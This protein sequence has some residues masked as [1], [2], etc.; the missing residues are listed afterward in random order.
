MGDPDRR[1]TRSPIHVNLTGNEERVAM[2][3]FELLK[4][5]GTGAYGKVFLVR[6]VTGP[7]TNHLYAMKVLQKC[8]LVKKEKTVE[9]TKTE[10]NVLEHVRESP[11]LVTLH[12]AFQ[13]EAKL[14]LILDY[15]SGGEL[16]TH[17]YQRDNFSEDAVRF[18]SGEVIL[19]LEHLHKLGVVYR[20]I[21]L[22]NILLDSEGHVVL[23]DFGLSKE[24]LSEEEERTYSFCGTT[25]YMAP[26]IIRGQGG[27]GKIVDWWSLGI[28]I[29][30]LLTGASPFTLEGE[31][32]TQSEVS[33]RILKMDPSLPSFLSFEARD[34]LHK[35]L[36]K[37]PK[38]RL[39]AAGA[40]QIKEHPFYKQDMDWEALSLRKVNPPF[41]PS[42]RNET[43][44]SNFAEEFTNLDPVYSPAGTPPSGA[45]VF[46]GYSFIAPSVL[47]GRNAVMRD[48]AA[49]SADKPGSPTLALSAA[50]KDSPFFQCYEIDL[51]EP[52][53]GSGS[54]SICRKCL[55]R[56]T[57]KEYAVKIISRRME[58]NTQREVAALRLCQGHTNIVALHEVLH[59]Q[60]HSYLV[61]ELLD[62][63]ELLDRIKKQARFSEV[64][65][66]SLM[67]SL[68]SAVAHM[69]SA[70]VVHRDL[71]PEN[72]LLSSPGENA[73]LKVI[74]FG[75]ARLRPPGSRPLHTPCF[76]LH[77]AAPELFSNQ[78]YDELCDLWTLGVILYTMLSGQVPFQVKRGKFHNRAADIIQKIKEGDFSMEG[79]CWEH[80]SEEAK[81]LVRGLLIVDPTCRL[82]LNELQES[83]WLRGGRPLSS[84]PLMT[85]D[86]LES[87]GL[88]T[89]NC[90][91]ATFMAF[92][93][94]KR[95]GVFLKSVDNAPLAKRRKLKMCSTGGDTRSGSS[96][97]S[98]SSSSAA[99]SA[100]YSPKSK[101]TPQSHCS[102]HS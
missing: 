15:V 95:E 19:A 63:G 56:Q 61:M 24:F 65:A 77:Y 31:K 75:F 78:G 83:D 76:T 35:L 52:A 17:L 25:E 34:L 36:R 84:T 14:H 73:V 81:D 91:D 23:T 28:L 54:Y 59:D 42:I 96:S 39:G 5:L 2:K 26:E 29:Y 93:R 70:G 88:A 37:D 21:K 64:E 99:A 58:A 1:E 32:N 16:F 22:E 33:R 101:G 3:D 53:L 67:R 12:Y 79:K 69:H 90:V 46:Q 102:G 97:S 10:R 89:K 98:S 41:R 66:S 20:D 92:N 45:P 27:H 55:H 8:A 50:M 71:K 48:M 60:Y 6:K 72:L 44:V 62:G 47:F 100:S 18:Y 7:D 9:H 80:V 87:S 49:P 30:E 13:T 11:F 82:S 40:S 86:V 74:D 85:P 57:Q 43:D 4:I 94:G 38:K 51:E 68:V